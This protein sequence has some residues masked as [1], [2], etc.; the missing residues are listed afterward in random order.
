[1]DCSP[2]S[3]YYKN[4]NIY[5]ELLETKLCTFKK[6]NTIMQMWMNFKLGV[7]ELFHKNYIESLKYLNISREYAQ[8]NNKFHL[9]L[10]STLMISNAL[11]M[12][13]KHAEAIQLIDILK[14]ESKYFNFINNYKKLPNKTNLY[15]SDQF[16]EEIE[17]L[18]I[19]SKYVI[20]TKQTVCSKIKENQTFKI[21]KLKIENIKNKIFK[22]FEKN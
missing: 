1:M 6:Q 19:K 5:L 16:Y 15:F 12:L 2:I 17:N 18:E 21:I 9:M 13:G 7:S 11:V 8:K 20:A 4:K 10:L 14:M 22:L 3:D